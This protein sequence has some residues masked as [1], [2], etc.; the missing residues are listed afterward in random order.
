MRSISHIRPMQIDD[1]LVKQATLLLWIATNKATL[2]K[3]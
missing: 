2:L 1:T 3:Q